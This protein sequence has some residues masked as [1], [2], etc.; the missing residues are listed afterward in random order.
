MIILCIR[1]S[2]IFNI[3]YSTPEGNPPEGYNS[4]NDMYVIYKSL[5]DFS[6]ISF[7]EYMNTHYW[8]G[9]DL[10]ARPAPLGEFSLWDLETL[11]WKVDEALLLYR[12][13]LTRNALL[14]MSDWTQLQDTALTQ[15]KKEEWSIYRQQLRDFTSAIQLI[16]HSMAEVPWPTPPA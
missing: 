6:N 4:D 11:S 16:Y 7:K 5:E 12:I 1:G 9:F 8:N 15:T 14:T 2:E 3:S 10:F 13:R